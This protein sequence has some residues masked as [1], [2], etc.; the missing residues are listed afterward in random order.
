MLD[1]SIYGVGVKQDVIS[2]PGAI[3][4]GFIIHSA[5]GP[6]PEKFIKVSPHIL[7]VLLSSEAP[8]VITFLL[9]PGD[10]IVLSFGPLFPAAIVIAIPK[11]HAASTAFTRGSFDDVL[12]VPIDK[13][14]TLI[15]YLCALSTSHC[16]PARTSAEFP[17]PSLFNIFIETILQFG[18]I[19][20]YLPFDNVPFPAA[21]PVT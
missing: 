19:P 8:T 14:A 7:T 9:I 6:R 18:A 4:S 12:F 13:L 11:S 15:L 17:F 1:E 3:T 20:Q 21:I 16:I 2:A 10:V 5:V